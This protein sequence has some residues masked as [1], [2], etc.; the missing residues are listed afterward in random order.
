MGLFT[1]AIGFRTK[2]SK[3]DE[4]Y[5]FER[6][7]F[8]GTKQFFPTLST[9][10]GYNTVCKAHHPLML[11]IFLTVRTSAFIWWYPGYMLHK[12]NLN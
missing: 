4:Y 5:F 11:Y 8:T 6:L 10:A 7:L 1:A 9:L 3:L 12:Q 2:F